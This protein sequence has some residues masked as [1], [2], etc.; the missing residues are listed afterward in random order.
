MGV[1]DSLRK[2][3]N[4]RP[5]TDMLGELAREQ[6]RQ[7]S[8]NTIL[9]IFNKAKENVNQY[10]NTPTNTEQT[11]VPGQKPR[12]N[13]SSVSEKPRGLNNN[14]LNA[15]KFGVPTND[16]PP[17]TKLN[18]FKLSDIGGKTIETG[19]ELPNQY[20]VEKKYNEE[21]LNAFIQAYGNQD[22]DPESIQSLAQLLTF[23]KPKAD[24]YESY[25]LNEGDSRFRE[26]KR[27][28]KTELIATGQPKQQ[29]IS[30]Y[31]KNPDGSLKVFEGPNGQKE[32][33]KITTKNGVQV[34]ED[35]EQLQF[36]PGSTNVYVEDNY[37][38]VNL[39]NINK[40]ISKDQ[41]DYNY[42]DRITKD[43]TKSEKDRKEAEDKKQIVFGRIKSNNKAKITQ[44]HSDLRKQGDK[45]DGGFE[46][47]I[48][49]LFQK[50]SGKPQ[51]IN[52]E[53]ERVM[54]GKSADIIRW[55]KEI[56]HNQIF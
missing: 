43:K 52:S 23:I 47:V 9:S 35:R 36:K 37:P 8:F 21:S 26:N 14:P 51:L 38:A 3:R 48:N 6:E 29:E 32:Y 39:A 42:Y 33:H 30:E 12:V 22:L 41:D 24:Q 17:S 44:I 53:V 25:N 4:L 34:K 2:A 45:S 50:L 31:V 49:L 20:D 11:F 1:A 40:D 55:T 28:G 54:Q 13:L 56:L 10:Q 27:T 16:A 7:E 5:V 19:G 18:P 15:D 46:G